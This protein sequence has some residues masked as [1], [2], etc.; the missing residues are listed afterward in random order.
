MNISVTEGKKA[1]FVPFIGYLVLF[2]A[3]WTVWVLF[4][5]PRVRDL[6]EATLEYALAN[7]VIRLIVWVA[8]VVVYLRYIDGTESLAYLKLR[9]H[10]QRGVLIGFAL[11][12]LNFLASVARYGWPHPSSH[13]VTWNSVVSTSI[14]VGFVEEIPYR[15]FILQKLEERTGFWAAN[16][17]SSLLFLAIHLPGWISLQ[18]LR[19]DVVVFVFVFGVVMA[20][21]FKYS[22]SLW[23]PIVAHSLNDFLSAIVF[24][25]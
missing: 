25:R 22:R 24:H 3:T 15:G 7:I 8:P 5:Y 10:W 6:G 21:V 18:L 1:G 4:I 20:I 19:G 2:H 14:L 17:I 23:A 9:N 13:W 11:T 12:A 16:L